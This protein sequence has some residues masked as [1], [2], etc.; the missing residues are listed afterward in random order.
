MR[1]AQGMVRSEFRQNFDK[2]SMGRIM[3][4]RRNIAPA[5]IKT[6]ILNCGMNSKPQTEVA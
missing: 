1:I 6:D 3:N 5:S 4:S 2:I